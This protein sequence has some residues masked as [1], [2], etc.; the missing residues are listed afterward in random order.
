[1]P[2]ARSSSAAPI[3]E[4]VGTAW[5]RESGVRPKTLPR[6]ALRDGEAPKTLNPIRRAARMAGARDLREAVD[7]SPATSMQDVADALGL[8]F[9]READEIAGGKIPV[10]WGEFVELV[11]VPVL[12]RALALAIPRRVERERKTGFE[13]RELVLVEHHIKSLRDALKR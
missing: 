10:T 11:P 2:G 8:E 4:L 7:A 9:D 6:P 13:P 3:R 5:A 12:V 1:M